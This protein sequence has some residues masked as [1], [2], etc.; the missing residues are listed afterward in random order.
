[1]HVV[2]IHV[3]R[4]MQFLGGCH[5]RR[6]KSALAPERASHAGKGWERRNPKNV[7]THRISDRP[8]PILGHQRKHASIPLPPMDDII[9]VRILL[10]VLFQPA[11]DPR[12]LDI[13]PER[14]VQVPRVSGG[15]EFDLVC[16]QER[17]RAVLI[18]RVLMRGRTTDSKLEVQERSVSSSARRSG[19]HVR[20]RGRRRAREEGRE[21]FLR[22]GAD[23]ARHY[24]QE[25][26]RGVPTLVSPFREGVFAR[27]QVG[28]REGALTEP[29]HSCAFRSRAKPFVS[30][31][32]R[33]VYRGKREME[34]PGG[35]RERE[36]KPDK[37]RRRAKEA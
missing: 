12:P 20:T 22:R 7:G 33:T 27:A 8:G 14:L 9:D 30:S 11:R 32:E 35:S 24:A 23:P 5:I 4:Q 16:E 36:A 18:G 2:L 10:E 31:R 26:G 19:I 29:F 13:G 3:K 17:S 37:P 34:R 6:Q 21:A 1:M 25:G 15:V 28:E